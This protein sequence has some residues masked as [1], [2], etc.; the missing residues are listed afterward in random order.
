MG[1]SWHFEIIEKTEYLEAMIS[2]QTDT[3]ELEKLFLKSLS[4]IES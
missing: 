1:Y 4:E 2:S 3:S